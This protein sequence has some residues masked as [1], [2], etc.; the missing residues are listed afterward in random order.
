MSE[1]QQGEEVKI[2][3]LS[4]GEIIVPTQGANIPDFPILMELSIKPF[5]NSIF[6]FSKKCRRNI[7]ILSS[8][9]L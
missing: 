8:R 6:A 2:D 5:S 4:L 7:Y 1:K 3:I 9:F